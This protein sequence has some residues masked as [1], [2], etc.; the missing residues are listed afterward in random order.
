[1]IETLRGTYGERGCFLAMERATG[2]EL[3]TRFL[4]LNSA[5]EHFDDIGSRDKFID[6]MLWY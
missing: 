4:E 1:M 5:A 2:L 3:A 6:E